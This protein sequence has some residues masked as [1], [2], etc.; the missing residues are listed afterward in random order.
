MYRADL[1]E[2]PHN[3]WALLGLVQSL[4][5]QHRARDAD[6]I[7]RELDGVWSRADITPARSAY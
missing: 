4:R 3:G 7:Q 6:R 1:A 2:H 5:A